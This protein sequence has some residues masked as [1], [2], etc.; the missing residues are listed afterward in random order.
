MNTFLIVLSLSL[1]VPNR[2]DQ[3]QLH[4]IH[5]KRSLHKCA[6]QQLC[7]LDDPGP[8]RWELDQGGI[9]GPTQ[10]CQSPCGEQSSI[11]WVHMI[12][13][14]YYLICFCPRCM[15]KYP[16]GWTSNIYISVYPYKRH[17]TIL[18]KE[19][20]T[21]LGAMWAFWNVP[22]ISKT[23]RDIETLNSWTSLQPKQ[24]CDKPNFWFWL[25]N[26]FV[27]TPVFKLPSKCHE[28][29]SRKK[30]YWIYQHHLSKT[31]RW[32]GHW[33]QDERESSN[34]AR[35]EEKRLFLR[36]F[37]EP[38]EKCP[39]KFSYTSRNES[40]N[41]KFSKRRKAAWNLSYHLDIELI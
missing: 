10:S 6:D 19:W 16:S 40:L 15:L 26:F 34:F 31:E 8:G 24:A 3:R 28:A 27:K 5:S 22:Q 23:K 29:F 38:H 33:Y 32:V 13:I 41:R 21:L 1:S 39:G 12:R 37:R 30:A 7:R 2:P 11:A 36:K 9:S 14:F 17:K 4:S 25:R 35:W 20:G 18:I